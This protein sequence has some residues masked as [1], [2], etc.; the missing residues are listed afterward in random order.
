MEI[1]E[2]TVLIN[3][4]GTVKLEVRGVKGKRCLSLTEGIEK[5]LGGQVIDRQKTPEH[6]QE[7]EVQVQAHTPIKSG[8]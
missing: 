1:E 5:A 8:W 7:A 3:P 2:L 4:D 6:D